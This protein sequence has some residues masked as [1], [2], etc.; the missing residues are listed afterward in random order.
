MGGGGLF[1]IPFR[2]F[3]GKCVL[4]KLKTDGVIG[5]GIGGTPHVE[6]SNMVGGILA[7]K[8]F[9]LGNVRGKL[10]WYSRPTNIVAD[11]I[12]DYMIEVGE[13]KAGHIREKR[14]IRGRSLSGSTG[15]KPSSRTRVAAGSRP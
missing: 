3:T 13:T 1:N 15:N 2:T 8:A 7:I 9:E 4:E 6:R 11:M 14:G 12:I 5:D 10:G